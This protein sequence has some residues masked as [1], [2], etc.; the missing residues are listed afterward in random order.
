[1]C[2]QLYAFLERYNILDD[3]QNGFRKCR[4][5]TLAVYKYVQTALQYINDKKHVIG[6]LLDMTKAYDKVLYNILLAKLYGC[7]VRG[8]AYLWF[9]SYLSNRTQLVQLKNFNSDKNEIQSVRS[10]VQK[11]TC[12]IPQ[13][14]VL[15]CI[16]FLIYINDLPKSLP[17]NSL[18]VLFADDISILI[19]CDNSNNHNSLVQNT[20]QTVTH[21]LKEHNLEINSNKTKI[22]QFRTYKKPPLVIKVI[23]QNTP[24]EEVNTF[25][26]LGINIDTHINWKTHIEHIK[27]KLSKFTYALFQINHSTNTQTALTA[28]YAYAYSWLRY[29]VMLWGNSVN[30]SE[31]FLLQKKCVRILAQIDNTQSCKPYFIKLNIL[32]L[33]SIYILDICIFVFKNNNTFTT[34]KEIHSIN[35]R[36]RDKLHLPLSRIKMLNESPYYMAVKIFNKLPNIIK[37]EKILILFT[38]RLRFYLIKKCY[39]TIAEFMD[40]N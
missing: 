10:Q 13:G 21:W 18:P 28:Y 37:K 30:M 26:L 11:I 15:G 17:E 33:P 20:L 34:K 4:S 3:S 8:P 7:G 39:Y 32:T 2:N 29:G 24:L 35:T 9:T 16:L 6:L 36:N 14:S 5:T 23:H 22:I 38:K 19:K 25:S 31:L 40:D 12:S 27:S 1:M